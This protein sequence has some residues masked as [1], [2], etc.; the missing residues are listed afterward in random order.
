LSWNIHGTCAQDGDLV[1]LVGTGY[2]YIIVRLQ[3]GTKLHSHRGIVNHDDLIGQPWGTRVESHLGNPFFMLQPS[4]ADLLRELKR[5][6]QILYPKEIGYILVI[7]LDDLPAKL[8]AFI[9]DIHARAC[10]QPS[11]LFLQLAA[12]RTF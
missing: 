6:T 5:N 2:K 1:E 12:E 10:D 7:L 11:D 3:A 4:L 8:D 9:A